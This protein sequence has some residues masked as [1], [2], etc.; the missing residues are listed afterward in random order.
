V[1]KRRKFRGHVPAYT[2]DHGPGTPAATAGTVLE[3]IRHDGGKDDPNR[4]ARRRRVETI[5]VL[6]FLSQRQ[7][8]AAR[9]IRDAYCA[10]QKL[11]SGS[12]LK[13]QVDTSSR[14]DA[15]VA[16]QVDALSRWRRAIDPVPR[17]MRATVE[18][19]CC[20]NVPIRRLP[21]YEVAR[22]DM[23]GAMTVVA[24]ALRY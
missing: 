21:N 2:G 22:S 23:Q 17:H 11:T 1:A 18:A 13:E 24:N 3:P 20:E 9:E 8:Q 16:A 19:I 6:T 7:Y 10:L 4:R 5:D 12:P 14:P 15:I